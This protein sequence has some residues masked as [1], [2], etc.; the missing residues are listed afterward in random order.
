M[1]PAMDE[2]T[3]VG[4]VSFD[5]NNVVLMYLVVSGGVSKSTAGGKEVPLCQRRPS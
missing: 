1:I 4:E 3:A 5:K 2:F